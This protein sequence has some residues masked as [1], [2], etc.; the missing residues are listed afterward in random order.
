MKRLILILA[1][2]VLALGIVS[3]AMATEEFV[4]SAQGE[5][6]EVENPVKGSIIPVCAGVDGVSVWLDV[7][8]GP[9][10][11]TITIDGESTSWT[12]VDN[13]KPWIPAPDFPVQEPNVHVTLVGDGVV[14]YDDVSIGDPC[15]LTNPD[16][17]SP[18]VEPEPVAEN[19]DPEPVAE[20][21][22]PVTG[23]DSTVL[24]I[25][26]PLLLLTGFTVLRRWST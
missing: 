4:P 25:L 12:A 1:T 26:G 20:E 11:F 23:I 13:G 17:Q 21:T 7:V 24:G 14:L 8:T 10:D 5:P 16:Y 3:P 18:T 22:L 2:V 6:T 19:T 9:G 15:P